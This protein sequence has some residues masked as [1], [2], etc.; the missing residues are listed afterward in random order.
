MRSGSHGRNPVRTSLTCKLVAR[1]RGYLHI[2]GYEWWFGHPADEIVGK[3]RE[4]LGNEA[5][6]KISPNMRRALAGE[7][8]GCEAELPY[9][10]GGSRWGNVSIFPTSMPK[11]EYGE[12]WSWSSI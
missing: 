11:T 2:H 6:E 9:K 8:V 12:S 5:W 3:T 4:V 10:G 7:S 1:C